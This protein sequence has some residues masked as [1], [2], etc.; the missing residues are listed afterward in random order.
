MCSSWPVSLTACFFICIVIPGVPSLRS[1]Q[2]LKYVIIVGS[3]ELDP[4]HVL[5]H[6]SSDGLCQPFQESPVVKS[7][8]MPAPMSR[9]T[10]PGESKVVRS[11]ISQKA[12]AQLTI[13]VA[14]G[15]SSYK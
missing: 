8:P 13:G 15:L 7:C 6:Y 10:F 5:P 1:P 9:N 12:W 4:V 3:S 11:I 14:A 2:W